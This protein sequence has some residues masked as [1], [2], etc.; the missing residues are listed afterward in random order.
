MLFVVEYEHVYF[1]GSIF[2]A[3]GNV[4]YREPL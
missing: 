3:I 2:D 1:I 4:N